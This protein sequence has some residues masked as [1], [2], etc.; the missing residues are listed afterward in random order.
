MGARAGCCLCTKLRDSKH[1]E[2]P[3]IAGLNSVGVK[4]ARSV[5]TVDCAGANFDHGAMGD[6]AS[7]SRSIAKAK[8]RVTAAGKH[9]TAGPGEEGHDTVLTPPGS[10][11]TTCDGAGETGGDRF[12]RKT[13]RSLSETDF[14]R[15]HSIGRGTFGQVYLVRER[16]DDTKRLFAMKVI[17]KMRV[18]VSMDRVQYIVTE[19]KVLRKVDH[20]FLARLR[21]AFQDPSRLFLVTDFCGGGELLSHLRRLVR[22]TEPQAMFFTAEVSLGLE[23]LHERGICHRDV[24]PE[25]V[26][27]D[28]A[29]HVKLI[30]FGLSK[31]GLA[32]EATT[33][34]ICGTPEYL[35]PEVLCRKSYGCELDWWS[36][37][38]LLFEMIEG[39]LPFQDSNK[40]H[41]FRL[42]TQGTFSFRYVHSQRVISLICSLLCPDIQTRLKS[43]HSVK[44]HSWFLGIDWDEA[45]ARGLRPPFKPRSALKDDGFEQASIE[46]HASPERFDCGLHIQGFSYVDERNTTALSCSGAS[47][48]CG[49][50]SEGVPTRHGNPEGWGLRHAEAAPEDC[51]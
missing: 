14:E 27:L 8:R 18:A 51:H 47:S 22:F 28:E 30:D 16:S 19:R 44:A 5:G 6:V 38:V 15:L 2:G 45:L 7:S 36:T 26:L 29:G 24:K 9:D 4:S 17:E 37:G 50:H 13:R 12:R 25:N 33:Q 41:M 39:R 42:I 31:T 35:A 48:P 1:D 3:G 34:T 21:F 32:G 40:Q 11:S 10:S 49:A 46:H 20:P 23:Y 43:A